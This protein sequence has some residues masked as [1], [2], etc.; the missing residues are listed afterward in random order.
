MPAG[1]PCNTEPSQFRRTADLPDPTR[2]VRSALRKAPQNAVV[3]AKNWKHAEEIENQLTLMMMR[4]HGWQRVRGGYWRTISEELTR[5]NLLHHQRLDELAVSRPLDHVLEDL[6]V[7]AEPKLSAAA[8]KDR[9]QRANQAWSQVE[10]TV[11]RREYDEGHS[12][13][14]IARQHCRTSVAIAARLVR[15][16]LLERRRDAK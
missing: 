4:T 14:A 11:L 5:R 3:V 1:A 10:D 6:Q 9:P 7:E 8:V 13:D 12:I 2:L 16:G 15:L